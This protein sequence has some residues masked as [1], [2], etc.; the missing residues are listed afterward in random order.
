MIQRIASLI[1]LSLT[2]CFPGCSSEGDQPADNVVRSAPAD[3]DTP[4]TDADLIPANSLLA[5]ILR[6]EKLPYVKQRMTSEELFELFGDDHMQWEL[7]PHGH[8]DNAKVTLTS[9]RQAQGMT[10]IS[11][12]PIF[13]SW[14]DQ[15]VSYTWG[16]HG[17]E[18]QL[19]AI[20]AMPEDS[21][22]NTDTPLVTPDISTFS[23]PD[24]LRNLMH[25]RPLRQISSTATIAHCRDS[26][27]PE[28]THQCHLTTGTTHIFQ[29]MVYKLDGSSSLILPFE[30][31]NLLRPR[32]LLDPSFGYPEWDLFT[33]QPTDRSPIPSRRGGMLP[34]DSF[35]AILAQCNTFPLIKR[36]VTTFEL[37][38][39]PNPTSRLHRENTPGSISVAALEE[40]TITYLADNG[41]MFYWTQSGETWQLRRIRIPTSQSLCPSNPTCSTTSYRP[42]QTAAT[43]IPDPSTYADPGL[44]ALLFGMQEL[45]VATTAVTPEQCWQYLGPE[46]S[47]NHKMTPFSSSRPLQ[48]AYELTPDIFLFIEFR[49]HPKDP[50]NMID[51]VSYRGFPDEE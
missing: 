46:L 49:G 35:L 11:T 23:A 12:G 31:G 17:D 27:G 28:D 45:D 15:H 30:N 22:G 43:P 16:R 19:V 32:V 20:E 34:D 6:C 36:E 24:L 33:S 2:I 7:A 37:L 18:W 47:N 26:L 14:S 3:A 48:L 44:A 50:A 21:Y 5:A 51:L 13:T 8:P 25:A 42:V 38:R 4:A 9:M 40:N 29:S 10:D 41:T 39:L 1:L